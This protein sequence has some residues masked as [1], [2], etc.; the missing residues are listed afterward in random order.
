VKKTK[1]AKH[2]VL[3]LRILTMANFSMALCRDARNVSHITV[4]CQGV[5]SA[6]GVALRQERQVRLVKEASGA[7]LFN[8]S[9]SYAY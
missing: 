2:P 8:N 4:V 6:T 9:S 3:I 1:C 7:I 5:A